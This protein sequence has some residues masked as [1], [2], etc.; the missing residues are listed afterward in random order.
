M[1]KKFKNNI[2]TNLDIEQ[3]VKGNQHFLGC[4][5][6]DTIPKLEYKKRWSMIVN[7][8]K[9]TQPGS[10]W[11]ALYNNPNHKHQYYF[12]SFGAP[13]PIEIERLKLFKPI[14]YNVSQIQDLNS[15]ACG[16][17]C[18]AFIEW[19]DDDKPYINFI[20]KF[21]QDFADDDAGINNEQILN[22][23]NNI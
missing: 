20:Y 16:Y 8:N 18:I 6:R 11:V 4:F 21:D 10:H 22:P 3:L 19:L 12:D 15:S 17:Y 13:P 2:L 7:L 23:K 14:A 5:S 1:N 9:S